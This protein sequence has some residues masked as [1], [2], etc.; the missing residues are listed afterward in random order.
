M[1]PI[2]VTVLLI[3]LSCLQASIAL[4]GQSV[5]GTQGITLRE[6]HATLK[7]V[8]EDIK[9]LTGYDFMSRSELLEIAVPVSLSVTGA[10]LE[11]VL[12]LCFRNQPLDYTLIGHT[13]VIQLKERP[14]VRQ[15]SNLVTVSG[16]IVDSLG[17]PVQAATVTL[18]SDGHQQAA[19]DSGRFVLAVYDSNAV[20]LVSSIG[21]ETLR[22]GLAGHRSLLVRLGGSSRSLEDFPVVY[23][24]FQGISSERATGSFVNIN[25]ELFDRSASP[26]VLDRLDGVTSGMIAT[27]NVVTGLNQASRSIRGRST[28]F[29]NPQP[30]VILDN[31]PYAGDI[32]N[33]NP[34]DVGSVTIL[35]DAASAS[36]WGV[37]SGNGV[38]V[39][40]TKKGMHGQAPQLS[41]SSSVTGTQRPNLFYMP[42]LTS[43]GY[44]DMEEYLF[45]QSFYTTVAQ[46]PAHPAYSPVVGILL[47]EQQGLLGYKEAIA[48]INRLRTLD[49]RYDLEKYFYRA[50]TTQQYTIGLN[51]G[52]A[53]DQYYLSAG[54]DKDLFSR[55]Y[56]SFQRVTL[57]GRNSW[58][59]LK[60]RLIFSM[61]IY[62]TFS[63][64]TDD[65]SGTSG[66]VYP[67]LQLADAQG[68]PLA[69]PYNLSQTYLDTAGNGQLL[70]WQYRPL[71]EIRLA[72]NT[73]RLTDYR[74]DLSI[75]YKIG[76]GLDLNVLYRYGRGQSDQQDLH[77]L[78]SYFTRNL[79]NEYSESVNGQWV[80]N[81]PPG[82]ILDEVSNIYN[83]NNLRL[84]AN[85]TYSDS[86]DSHRFSV[87][88]GA[89]G[90]DLETVSSSVRLYGYDPATRISQPVN[91]STEYPLYSQSYISAQIP[92]NDLNSA[93]TERYLSYF[94]NGSY[95]Y[96]RRYV[97]TVGAR[98]DESNFFGSAAN[99]RG[100]PLLT[101]GLAWDLTREEF[102]RLSWLKRCK[103]RLTDGYSGN[104]DKSISALTT[105]TLNSLNN[106]GAPTASINNPP[107]SSLGWEK[108]HIINIGLDLATASDRITGSLD[109]YIKRGKDLIGTS[110]LDPTT[111]NTQFI[112][113]TA[114]MKSHGIDLQL[115]TRNR[116]GVLEWSVHFLFSYVGNEVTRY[117]AQLSS[118]GNYLPPGV[119][120]PL[121]GHPLYSVYALRW[122]GLD[123]SD[124]D[125]RG[126]YQH[127]V[128]KDYASI[129]QSADFNDLLYKGSATP[130]IF[131]SFRNDFGWR[132]FS[133]SVNIVYE[134]GYYFRRTSIDYGSV[135]SQ[136][137]LGS[138]D[139]Y[140]RWQQPGDEKTTNVP[141]MIYP[142]NTQRDAFYDYSEVLVEK[143]DNIRLRDIRLSYGLDRQKYK[144]L[145]FRSLVCYAYA[146][147]IGILW[148]A[149]HAGLDP[150]YLLSYPRPRSLA[151]GIKMEW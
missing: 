32:R 100:A 120:S 124:G 61:G 137:S 75:K 125:P 112:G 74:I 122:K 107:N 92:Y 87:L 95:T 147:N 146:N 2:G 97:V 77:S 39:I 6:D 138:P 72:N 119:I 52:N 96:R 71:E 90:S 118:I 47:R 110:P 105:I 25:R 46:S 83:S 14:S 133:L 27:S 41:F 7:K 135:F 115:N 108:T 65:N 121:A 36:V 73:T 10:T 143:G 63:K 59:L 60:D 3:V 34:E 28:I 128:S 85:Y 150:D 136:V 8:F 142:D 103:L 64:T 58:S 45:G 94:A 16:R 11:Q 76:K 99:K 23:D 53:N 49:T 86:R 1:R 13:I 50:H 145:P 24:G 114:D 69:I 89:E 78:Q 48:E 26:D 38:I 139:F 109:G 30:L 88:A 40:T 4:Y 62:Y 123:P 54:L 132:H 66:S 56:N 102:Y 148:K 141:S 57:N 84:Q 42:I 29:G 5:S 31:F 43:P 126:W 20:L 12:Y 93:G 35:R 19:D 51:G 91:Y 44:I 18:E 104:I 127:Q 70:N 151:I 9:D 21:F 15:E 80:R 140:K 37:F 129:L 17:M 68:R 81:I 149:N 33:I 67:Y 134:A 130:T 116:L 113:N 22:I 79:V 55:D 131:G 82:D 111:G 98:K 144:K 101:A 117:R 106:Y